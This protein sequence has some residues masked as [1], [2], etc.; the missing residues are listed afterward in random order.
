MNPLHKISV[1][2][3][4]YNSSRELLVAIDSVCDQTLLPKEVIIVDDA[5]DDDI[6]ASY[7]K[8]IHK[9]SVCAINSTLI[10][11]NK[12]MGPSY[13]RNKGVREASFEFV[14]FLDSDDIWHKEKLKV[15]MEVMLSN[16]EITLTGHGV[17]FESNLY[18]IQNSDLKSKYTSTEVSKFES[19]IKNPLV[20]TSTYM[21]RKSSNIFFNEAQRHSEDY[22]FFL[23]HFFSKG[24]V[25]IINA[26]LAYSFKRPFG[27]TGLSAK[28]LKM[29][30]H[31]LSNY[32][33]LYRNRHIGFWLY[34][35]SCTFSVLKFIRRLIIVLIY[36]LIKIF[37]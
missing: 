22:R 28:L 35:F 11:N 36:R 9:L 15:Q 18:S 16:P 20:S 30:L 1:V 13:C 21:M 7:N 34:S 27:D 31:E 5:S 4:T 26:M 6:M 3:T 8:V 23:E 19:L 14:A 24:K 29:E 10:Q 2:I 12:N 32:N 25:Y 17:Q 33:L 37:E